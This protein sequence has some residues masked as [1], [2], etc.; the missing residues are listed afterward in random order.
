M[1]WSYPEHPLTR[2]FARL[3]EWFPNSPE[4]ATALAEV[5]RKSGNATYADPKDG[6]FL[7]AV[8]A[9][10]GSG[11]TPL[12]AA[13]PDRPAGHGGATVGPAEGT[14][15]ARADNAKAWL[16]ADSLL[17]A[18]DPA[19]HAE[20][21]HA[22]DELLKHLLED[23]RQINAFN[24]AFENRQTEAAWKIARQLLHNI[25]RKPRM[26]LIERCGQLL[27]ATKNVDALFQFVFEQAEQYKEDFDLDPV[28]GAPLTVILDF[29]LEG[30]P[31]R[32]ERWTTPGPDFEYARLMGD[33]ADE[34]R[35]ESP[36]GS[37]VQGF[38]GHPPQ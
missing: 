14:C 18:K 22:Y 27:K 17:E 9:N 33:L 5:T 30:N 26:A 35:A 12:E 20:A 11:R 36:S 24:A 37:C 25:Q 28:T 23:D 34:M 38:R 4:A 29:T 3:L 16:A 32:V 2:D 31:A 6:H 21:Q 15:A 1:A 7:A 8:F 19:I 13:P 10:A